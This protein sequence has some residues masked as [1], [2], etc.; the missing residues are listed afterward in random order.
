MSFKSSIPKTKLITPFPIALTVS[1]RSSSLKVS[2][3]FSEENNKKID[4][5]NNINYDSSCNLITKKRVYIR[6]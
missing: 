1:G 5:N 4:V 2:N 3:K 6:T